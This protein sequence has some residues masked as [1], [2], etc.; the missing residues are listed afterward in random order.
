M[1]SA[2]VHADQQGAIRFAD[3]R[4]RVLVITDGAFDITYA[5]VGYLYDF[6]N[7]SVRTMRKSQGAAGGQ[8]SPRL[9]RSEEPDVR[10]S[11]K[12][13]ASTGGS[14]RA[15]RWIEA[16]SI[17]G[18]RFH[19]AY[20]S[21][22]RQPHHRGSIRQA[23]MSESGIEKGDGE[24]ITR[25][26]L[27]DA[28]ISTSGDYERFF[29]EAGCA[30]TTSSIRTPAI[31]RARCAAH[32]HR[33]V[34]QRTDGLSK[35]AFVLA[36]E[37]HGD[38]QP[39]RRHRCHHRQARRH[40]DLFQGIEPHAEFPQSNVR[41][42]PIRR[43]DH[44]LRGRIDRVEQHGRRHTRFTYA[45]TLRARS[46]SRPRHQADCRAAAPTCRRRAPPSLQSAERRN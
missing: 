12:G 25:I 41:P 19:R 16:S 17:E 46:A 11:Q 42:P 9:A 43:V 6:R 7:T 29:E 32:H 2:D 37:G 22:A 26:P 21:P 45:S 31:P 24:V 15:T 18:A 20:V 38:L 13:C 8:L 30:T 39:H 44:R 10:F 5:S 34:C 4:R 14:P 36:G 35:T 1:P 33:A 3:H 27:V 40:R 28:A 23:W